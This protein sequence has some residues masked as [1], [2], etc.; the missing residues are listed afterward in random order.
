[1]TWRKRRGGV[2]VPEDRLRA[3]LWG[4]GVCTPLSVLLTGLTIKYVPGTPG[5][6]LNLM[7]M[8][9]NGIGV[10]ASLLAHDNRDAEPMMDL[11][12]YHRT[13]L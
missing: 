2:W 12:L 8:F 10:R 3:A 5:L 4:A 13:V 1:M 11:P 6:V 9:L 7:W